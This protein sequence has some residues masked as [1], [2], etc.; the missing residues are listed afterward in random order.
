[1]KLYSR[2]TPIATPIIHLR[3]LTSIS[4]EAL[5]PSSSACLFLGLFSNKVDI[6]G[7]VC[8][9]GRGETTVADL[10]SADEEEELSWPRPFFLVRPDVM[11]EAESKG[12]WENVGDKK[13]LLDEAD[14]P[15]GVRANPM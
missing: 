4:G 13:M 5:I 15:A 11:W 12:V 7:R 1:M 6:L 9:R 14:E 8:E 10:S 3:S 2:N